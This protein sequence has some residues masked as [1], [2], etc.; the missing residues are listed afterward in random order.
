MKNITPELIEK[1]KNAKSIEKLKSIAAGA[2]L[3]YSEEEV[4][5]F[6]QKLGIGKDAKLSDNDLEQIAGGTTTINGF[7]T[8]CVTEDECRALGLNPDDYKQ[9]GSCTING[10]PGVNVPLDVYK[11][12]KEK[13][14]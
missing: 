6:A 3:S 4:A 13:K 14:K 7:S 10:R 5:G 11:N 2:G 1:A 9:Y 8:E 12:A